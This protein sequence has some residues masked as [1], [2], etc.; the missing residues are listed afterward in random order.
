MGME[1][2]SHRARLQSVTVQ[3]CF[4]VRNISVLVSSLMLS[5]AAPAPSLAQTPSD[6][7]QVTIAPYFIGASMNGTSVVAGQELTVDMSFSD[8]LQK[9]Q[10]GAMGL[11]LARK[12]DWGVGADAIWMALGANGTAPGPAGL[13]GS[14]DVNQGAFAFYGRRRLSRIA[15]LMFG[16]R[17]NTLQT[18]LG[19]NGT[20]QRSADGSKTWFDPIVGL[21]LLIPDDGKRWHAQAYTEIG[22]FGVGSTFSWQVFPTVGVNLTKRASLEF[23]YRWLDIN[24]SS[25]QNLT[26]F[27]Y[28]VLTQG[29][30]MGLGLRF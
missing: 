26:L 28:D 24:Y 5:I 11:V 18:S 22:G 16:G 1:C 3:R 19:F 12:G 23:G 21:Q 6:E 29:P 13:T 20:A 17:L 8:I 27:K 25:G 4:T 7:W 14:A 30:V 15:D 9:L 10:F 2:G